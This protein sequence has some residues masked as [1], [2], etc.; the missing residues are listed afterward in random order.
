M[1]EYLAGRDAHTMG[2][3]YTFLGL[4]VGCVTEEMELG[5][6][7]E[8]YQRDIVYTTGE[9][10]ER[11]HLGLGARPKVD[12]FGGT[13]LIRTVNRYRRSRA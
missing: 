3:V 2:K 5:E 11:L 7:Q 1:N 12:G 8:M 10:G 4:S 9:L 6:K 13:S